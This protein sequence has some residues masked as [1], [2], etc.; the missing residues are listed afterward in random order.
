MGRDGYEGNLNDRVV[1]LPQLLKDTGYQHLHGRQVAP[2][3]GAP[4]DPAARGF[5]RDF[6]LLDGMGSYWDD[7]GFAVASPKSLYTEDGRYLTKLPKNFY[8]TQTYTDKLIDYIDANH[9]DGKPFFA[10]VSHQAPH[11]PY[12]LPK[13]WRSATSASTT[14]AMT[15][16][17]RSA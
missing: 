13:E 6:T 9:G 7:M 12:H 8:A 15:H 10:Y 16:Y 11:E 14:R 5:E 1:T 17:G 2:G 3:E 4:P